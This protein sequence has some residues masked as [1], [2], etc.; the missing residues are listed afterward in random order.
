MNRSMKIPVLL[1]LLVFGLVSAAG[2]YIQLVTIPDR[3]S[4]QMTIY[5]SED[6]TL[7]KE[8]RFISFKKGINKIEFSWAGTLIDPTSVQFKP[9]TN[10]D[11]LEILDTTFPA[12]IANTLVWHIS[13]EVEGDQKV[14][15][16]Y[17][18]SGLTWAADYVLIANEDETS[19]KATAY[20]K[21]TNNSG[22][23]YENAQ[24]RL[25]VGEVNLVEDI[26]VLARGGK[27]ERLRGVIDSFDESVAF[28]AAGALA[29]PKEIIKEGLSEY[30]IYTIEGTETI[31]TTWSKRLRSFEVDDVPFEVFFRYD[32]WKHGNK[33]A[34]M[35][36]L[37]NDEEHKL[38]KEPLPN[39]NI[40]AFRENG[41]GGLV[42]L[43]KTNTEYIPIKEDIE[44]VLGQDMELVVKPEKME[45]RKYNIDFDR[46]GNVAGWDTDD[47][48]RV[49]II[50][51]KDRAVR[52]E[53]VQHFNG[54]WS[55]ETK[56]KYEK[57]DQNTVKFIIDI[58]A[59]AN[60]EINYKLTTSF[61][62]RAGR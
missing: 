27:Q 37:K 11:K 19:M 6:L 22:E 33:P 29:K 17:F 50:N 12:N 36:K 34:R 25:V 45:F 13:S 61:G 30:F 32:E 60:R 14:E 4:V 28:S 18:T 31:P 15:I 51:G 24:T 46:Y 42:F 43:G 62:S 56:D 53:L 3:D 21:V 39:G 55:L 1:C 5:N 48:W 41:D 59:R 9:I 2:A 26:N 57:V 23:D 7:I 35:F 20:V 58:P 49:K 40:M 16:L 54:A 10:P 52:L 47:T 44:A 8:N 38:G